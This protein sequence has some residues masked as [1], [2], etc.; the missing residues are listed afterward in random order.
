MVYGASL[1]ATLHKHHVIQVI[2]PTDN[3]TCKLENC[4]VNGAAYIAGFS[5]SSH[6]SRTFR[7]HFGMSIRD[8]QALIK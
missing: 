5:D 3:A 1:D 2:W 4:E 6:L 8:A 7:A